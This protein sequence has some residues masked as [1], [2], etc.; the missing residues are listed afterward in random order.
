MNDIKS[1]IYIGFIT[2]G[3]Q[4]AKYLPYFLPSLKNQ[5]FKDFKILAIDNSEELDNENAKYIKNNFT[6]LNKVAGEVNQK[7]ID[8]A[9]GLK[10]LADSKYLMGFPEINLR[11]AGENLGFAKAF[12]LMIKKAVENGAEYFLALNPDMILEAE[13]IE[14]L[15]R[16]ARTDETIAAVQP[17]ILK[18][19]FSENKKTNI[20]DSLGLLCDQK[21]RFR[22]EKQGEIDTMTFEPEE[23]F[24]FTGAA[25]LLNLRA[26]RDTAF[27][28]GNKLEYFDELMFMYKEDCDLS[29][30]LRLAGW[31]IMLAPRAVAYHDRAH[32][33]FGDSLWRVIKNRR[34]K[35]RLLK[36][37]SNWGQWLIVLKYVRLSFSPRTKFLIWWY[38]LEIFIFM[39]LFEQYLLKDFIGI[40]R[41]RKSV[42]AR[43][44][45]L[46][47]RINLRELEALMR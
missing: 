7:N 43:R 9:D 15:V 44:E 33:R 34:G 4:T 20:I 8:I 11:W 1:K 18:W 17:K 5:T 10:P 39:V 16:V 26:L 38:E 28:D 12:N 2:Y 23:I 27:T 32:S 47:V 37:W 24:G 40:W 6:P 21:F 22:D 42:A 36:I 45:Q 41:E 29:L 46:K 35:K 31:K 13:A 19:N 3:N 14:E 30:R 25:A